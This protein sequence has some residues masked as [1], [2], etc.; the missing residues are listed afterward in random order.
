[1]SVFASG[2]CRK[3]FRSDCQQRFNFTNIS[4]AFVTAGRD[5]F[6]L[7]TIRRYH[8]NRY[9][10]FNFTTFPRVTPVF[11]MY[12]QII[13]DSQIPLNCGLSTGRFCRVANLRPFPCLFLK[14]TFLPPVHIARTDENR[15]ERTKIR[16]ERTK[17]GMNGRKALR[18]DDS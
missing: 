15:H 17:C 12:S 9:I 16:Q 7:T 18:T 14:K 13:I 6:Y 5:Y 11:R 8:K 4:V 1:M 3:H 10:I 2:L